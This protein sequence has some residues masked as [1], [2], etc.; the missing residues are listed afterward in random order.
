MAEWVYIQDIA[1]H[2]GQEVTIKGWLYDHTDKGKLQFLLVRDGTGLIQ[3]VASQKDLPSQTFADAQRVTQESSLM[4]TGVVRADRRAPG[5]HEL[6]LTDIELV[7]L[8]EDYPIT[9]KEHGIEFLMQQRHLW[10]RSARQHAILHI[11]A[12]VIKAVRDWLDGNGFFMLRLMPWSD[13]H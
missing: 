12:E 2:E 5:G 6:S 13:A 11:R 3:C 1:P 10:I 9:P 4:V 8:A 7:Q